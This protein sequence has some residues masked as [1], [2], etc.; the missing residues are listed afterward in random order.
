MQWFLDQFSTPLT[1]TGF[2]FQ[3]EKV[4]TH[5]A[6][7]T[8]HPSEFTAADPVTWRDVA[9]VGASHYKIHPESGYTRSFFMPSLRVLSAYRNIDEHSVQSWLVVLP[10]QRAEFIVEGFGRPIVCVEHGKLSPQ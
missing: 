3:P 2:E 9:E 10:G 8:P 6:T 5:G 7:E 4:W 1:T